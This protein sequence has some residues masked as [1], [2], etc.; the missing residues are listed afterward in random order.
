MHSNL[1]HEI[2]NSKQRTKEKC[3]SYLCWQFCA[4]QKLVALAP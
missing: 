1:S 2:V 3:K 4:E